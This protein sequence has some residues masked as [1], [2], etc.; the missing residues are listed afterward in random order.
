MKRDYTANLSLEQRTFLNRNN[1]E[2]YNKSLL[3][4]KYLSKLEK[5]NLFFQDTTFKDQ[6]EISFEICDAILKDMR[7][8][9]ISRIKEELKD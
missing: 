7:Q 8:E 6:R 3:N 9:F 2:E 5:I 1:I 4:I